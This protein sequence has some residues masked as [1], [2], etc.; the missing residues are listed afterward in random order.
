MENKNNSNSVEEIMDIKGV[1]DDHPSNFFIRRFTG[2]I[3][4]EMIKLKNPIRAYESFEHVLPFG[5]FKGYSLEHINEFD[6]TYVVFLSTFDSRLSN[7]IKKETKKCFKLFSEYAKKLVDPKET[8]IERE[9]LKYL[10]KRSEE[11]KWL[12]K[13]FK[14]YE[15]RGRSERSKYFIRSIRFQLLRQ[16]RIDLLTKKQLSIIA[17]IWANHYS[18]SESG[19]K[20]NSERNKFKNKIRPYWKRKYDSIEDI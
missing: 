19:E 13:F 14:D 7:G 3:N 8:R 15:D 17:N 9:K 20:F 4:C 12:L 5:V 18:E 10:N 16:Y 11:I 6:H 2:K 1:G